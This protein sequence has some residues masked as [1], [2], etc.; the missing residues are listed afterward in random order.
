MKK[1]NL[2]EEAE[3]YISDLIF[4]N[5]SLEK[6]VQGFA[7]DAFEQ[8][9]TSDYAKQQVTLGQIEV[10]ERLIAYP[11]MNINAKIKELKNQLK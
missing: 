3:K 9:A 6:T 4:K 8:G 2:E 10:L 11:Y 7:F 5:K 1:L